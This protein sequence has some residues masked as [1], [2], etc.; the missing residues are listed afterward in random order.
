VTDVTLA[1]LPSRRPAFSLSFGTTR[2]AILDSDY[3]LNQVAQLV[4][5]PVQA[6]SLIG[7][8]FRRG[9]T[10]ASAHVLTEL[11]QSDKLGFANKWEKLAHQA[12]ERGRLTK[13]VA[14]RQMFEETFLPGITFVDVGGMFVDAEAARAVHAI[15]PHDAPTGQLA[16]LLSRTR[17]IVYAHDKSLWRPGLA[18]APANFQAVLTAGFRVDNSENLTQ[19]FSYVAGG[20]VWAVDGAARG[21]S[22]MLKV[23]RWVPWLALIGGVTWYLLGQERRDRVVV[24]LRPVGRMLERE[25]EISTHALGTLADAVAQVEAANQLECRIA[26]VLAELPDEE[27]LTAAELQDS[28]TSGGPPIE[29]PS[30]SD[31][32]TFMR[33]LPCF[34]EGPTSRFRLGHTYDRH[35]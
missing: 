2:V 5:D 7:P 24:A 20:V 14:Y 28:M 4:D 6:L 13:P 30:A 16:V 1:S 26:E 12:A 9:R 18:P 35:Q 23:P 3:I 15:D 29:L 17:P 25:A 32:R 21:V 11:Y 22:V 31:M 34:V 8:P 19:G 27:A 33:Q 10:F